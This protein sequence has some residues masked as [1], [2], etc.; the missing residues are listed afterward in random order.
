MFADF[1]K[2]IGNYLKDVDNNILLDLN[3]QLST[4]PLGYNHPELLK[5]FQ[6]QQNIVNDETCGIQKKYI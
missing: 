2:S 3:M 6:N 1:E 5:L 4:I